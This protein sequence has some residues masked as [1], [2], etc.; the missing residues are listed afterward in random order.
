M[1]QAQQ[2]DIIQQTAV[3]LDVQHTVH[4]DQVVGHRQ[5]LT[6]GIFHRS[7]LPFQLVHHK[8]VVAAAALVRFKPLS[9]IQQIEDASDAAANVAHALALA[10]VIGGKGGI[11][12]T[13]DVAHGFRCEGVVFGAQ[14]HLRH[15]LLPLLHEQAFQ[16][17]VLLYST[18]V[19][20]A[21]QQPVHRTAQTLERLQ[22][23]VF[24]ILQIVPAQQHLHLCGQPDALGLAHE[25]APGHC[26]RD[27]LA[28]AG[29]LPPGQTV[30]KDGKQHAVAPQQ[31]AGI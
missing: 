23:T 17:R 19:G 25:P 24:A 15:S 18:H 11:Q 3:Q 8:H 10:G 1:M 30:R 6:A 7:R 4:P 14:F 28:L 27:P 16:C 29:G 21:Q 31:M 26:A 20:A 13:I 9:L 5:R 2:H 22:L 12:G